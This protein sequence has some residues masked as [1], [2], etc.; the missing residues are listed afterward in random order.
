MEVDGSKEVSQDAEWEWFMIT[1]WTQQSGCSMDSSLKWKTDIL[2]VKLL[3]I[4]NPS[5][6]L[7]PLSRNLYFILLF[8]YCCLLPL[9]LFLLSHRSL[10]DQAPPNWTISQK[11]SPRSSAVKRWTQSPGHRCVLS[12]RTFAKSFQLFSSISFS[13]MKHEGHYFPL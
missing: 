11:R 2:S 5:S 8:L 4:L 7:T 13:I 9:P 3:P 6:Q 12:Q 10:G 1:P